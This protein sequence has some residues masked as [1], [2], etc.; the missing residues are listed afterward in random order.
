MENQNL[1]AFLDLQK[2]IYHYKS[3]ATIMSFDA[4]TI[5]PIGGSAV[6]GERAAFFGL[7]MY[8]LRTSD[9][10]KN[11]LDA[12][13]PIKDTL[14]IKYQ[15]MLREAKKTY[16]KLTKIPGELVAKHEQLQNDA[17]DIWQE[18]RAKDDFSLFAPILKE[19]I[20]LTKEMLEY[21]KEE[22]KTAYE[23]LLGDFE[24][25]MS[26]PAY[27][28][29]FEDLKKV[30]VPLVKKVKEAHDQPVGDFIF[31]TVP[32]ESQRALGKM[33]AEKIGYDLS[34]GYIGETAHPFCSGTDKYDT[35]ITTRYYEEDFKASFYG[36][37]HETGHAIYE[38]SVADG[39]FGTNIDGGVSMGIHESQSR[40]YENVIGRSK[41]FW[42]CMIEEVKTF[43]PE[44]FADK[45][46][47]DFYEALNIAKPSLIRVE[48]DEL[49]YCLHIIIRYEIERMLF[50]D[51]IEVDQLPAVWNAKYEEYLGITP[52]N[53]AEG[54]LQDI[55]WSMGA[56]GYFPTYALGSAYAA[57]FLAY[58]KKEFDVDA[59][60]RAGDFAAIKK[61]LTEHI[62]QYGATYPPR[63]LVKR[64]A[65]EELNAKYYTDYLTEKFH[66]VY[67]L[68]E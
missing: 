5:A 13:L 60:V 58:M 56:Y 20:A 42:E 65:G 36:I 64:I 9:E 57:Q 16:D 43:L 15:A 46:A 68:G 17:M 49:T 27:D 54:V 67:H 19:L 23:V 14:E 63:E 50:Q 2:R 31:Q 3:A 40:F 8:K 51:E 48:A 53:N 62:H 39:L 7:E 1:Q 47:Q 6:R 24:E 44:T 59:S 11:L 33:I 52:P 28:A 12:L 22:G 41:A 38:Q 29:F 66:E 18:A 55:H 34:R 37:I 32:V 25:G 4:S 21:R 45:N 26:I 61:W 30:I 10:M 35:R